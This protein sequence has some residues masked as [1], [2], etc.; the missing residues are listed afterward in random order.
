VHHRETIGKRV[1]PSQQAAVQDGATAGALKE[2]QSQQH[3]HLGNAEFQGVRDEL[4]PIMYGGLVTMASTPYGCDRS[5][6]K[7]TRLSES[8]QP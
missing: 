6:R 8:G 7:S 2:Q 1:D 5:I 4:S 3:D